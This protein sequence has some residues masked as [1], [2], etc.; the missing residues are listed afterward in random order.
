MSDER[1][2]ASARAFF[3]ERA[4]DWE[5]RF[6]DDG[7][8][9]A[10]AVAALSLAAG[11]TVVDLACGTG[12]ALPLLREAVGPSG[13]VVAVDYV[14]EM[15]GEAARRGRDRLASLVIADAMALPLA[16]GSVD[17]VFAAGLISH[18]PAPLE[19]LA[20]M[21]RVCRPGGRLAIFHPIGRAALAARH[22]RT[23]TGDELHAPANIVPGLASVG[24]QADLVDDADDR[25][26]VVATRL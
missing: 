26:L 14:P 2:R 17:A 3:A 12:R 10:E 21:A 24:W 19:A 13:V 22:G 23:L 6:P 9:Y 16:S 25:Y 11:A 1:D 7:P 18:L 8:K 20:G 5:E 15:L 4:A